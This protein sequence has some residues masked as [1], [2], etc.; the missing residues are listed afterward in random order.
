[1]TQQIAGTLQT[2]RIADRA[3]ALAAPLADLLARLYIARV[4]LLSGWSKI[5][6]WDTTLYLF[7]DE[8]RVPLFPSKLA[9]VL[10]TGGEL[11]FPVLLVLGCFTRLS[12]L[13]LFCLNIVAVASYWHVLMDLPVALD[14]HL[15][16]ALMLGLLMTWQG[17]RWEILDTSGRYRP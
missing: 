17:R 1:M 6:D 3:L 8:Y 10:G 4:F 11:L 16:W 15:A 12:A 9:A 5:S 7:A 14:D 2:G 13:G